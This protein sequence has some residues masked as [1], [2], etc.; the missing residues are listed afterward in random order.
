MAAQPSTIVRDAVGNHGTH[1]SVFHP[2][3]DGVL[4]DVVDTTNVWLR[5]Q[6]NTFVTYAGEHT[7]LLAWRSM[8]G[9]PMKPYHVDIEANL[10]C[11]LYGVASNAYMIQRAFFS[12][13]VVWYRENGYSL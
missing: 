10:F 9:T 1:A 7:P 11:T 3:Y 2:G 8:Y 12:T 5:A 6:C 13:E 4:P